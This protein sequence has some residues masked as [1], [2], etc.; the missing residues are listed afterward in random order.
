MTRSPHFL[1]GLHQWLDSTFVTLVHMY[2]QCAPWSWHC[3]FAACAPSVHTGLDICCCT[4]CICVFF[5]LDISALWLDI[6]L[7]SCTRVHYGLNFCSCSSVHILID[8]KCAC[9]VFTNKRLAQ[10]F[11]GA[12]VKAGPINQPVV[13][14]NAIKREGLQT[15]PDAFLFLDI[16]AY[17]EF[18]KGIA[19][20]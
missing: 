9:P 1:V 13:S 20:G 17:S 18:V 16:M 10:I 15:C 8:E 11:L 4:S 12:G 2:H 19:V 3:F 6:L 7:S 14:W 5:A